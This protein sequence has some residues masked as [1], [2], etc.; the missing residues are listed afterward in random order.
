MIFLQ[1]K[2]DNSHKYKE[3][4]MVILLYQNNMLFNITNVA[5]DVKL[6][7]YYKI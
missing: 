7:N 3:L 1:P 5:L 2:Y 6:L 4:L